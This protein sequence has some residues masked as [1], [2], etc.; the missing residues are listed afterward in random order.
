MRRAAIVGVH[1]VSKKMANATK[2]KI[3]STQPF[4]FAN[5]REQNAPRV[6]SWTVHVAAPGTLFAAE[7]CG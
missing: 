2:P 7:H 1:R 6:P 5:R 4:L 3:H